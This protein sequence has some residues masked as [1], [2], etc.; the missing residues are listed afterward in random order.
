MQSTV[1]KIHQMILQENTGTPDEF[2]ALFHLSRRQIY[3]IMSV[4]KDYGADIRF[5]RTKHTFY[6][7]NEFKMP[8]NTLSLL[9]DDDKKDII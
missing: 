5:S 7:A 4:L 2:A 1:Y 3:N 8:V 9:S 6:Y